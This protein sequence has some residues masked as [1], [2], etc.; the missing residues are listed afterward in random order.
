[1]TLN[2][3]HQGTFR[4][5]HWKKLVYSLRPM[6]NLFYVLAIS[7]GAP[8]LYADGPFQVVSDFDDTAKITNVDDGSEAVCNTLFKRTT[9]SGMSTL[10]REFFM[11][12]APISFVS[13]GVIHWKGFTKATLKANDI[14]YD[15]VYVKPF[16][17]SST[18]GFKMAS[19]IKILG[20]NPSP[21]VLIGDDTQLD[22]DIYDEV[23]KKYPDQVPAI[24][25]HR[26]K[27]R[28]MP[29][30][31]VLRT[32]YTAY[33]VAQSEYMRGRLNSLQVQRVA[34]SIL[35]S[36]R[37]GLFPEYS[38]CPDSQAHFARLLNE[39]QKDLRMAKLAQMV[40]DHI[41]ELCR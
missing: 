36:D 22:P 39:S 16:L 24:Y 21:M 23:Q 18:Y 28:P 6:K 31:P 10:Y 27:G 26:V 19:I 35:D 17:A 7:L 14:P 41:I 8:T 5:V 30:N 40:V 34:Q 25:I 9:F 11:A 3:I 20:D 12:Y 38:I 37:D 2:K 33:E 15:R 1:M 4:P 13:G 29:K 32:Y